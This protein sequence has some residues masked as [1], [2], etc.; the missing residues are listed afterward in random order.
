MILKRGSTVP[1]V[2]THFW[3]RCL[4]TPCFWEL[5]GFTV[6]IWEMFSNLTHQFLGMVHKQPPQF[7][8]CLESFFSVTSAGG[9]GTGERGVPGEVPRHLLLFMKPRQGP[10]SGCSGAEEWKGRG[11]GKH[12][13]SSRGPELPL[14]GLGASS[15]SGN[16]R[17]KAVAGASL[18]TLPAPTLAR[19]S[20]DTQRHRRSP[21]APAHRVGAGAASGAPHPRP[22]RAAAA[23]SPA[24]G[25]AR[26]RLSLRT[27]RS[28]SGARPLP[29]ARSA[30]APPPGGGTRGR[31]GISGRPY[32]TLASPPS[33]AS[34]WL[35][36]SD[37][38]LT[39]YAPQPEVAFCRQ[40]PLVCPTHLLLVNSWWPWRSGVDSHYFPHSSTSPHLPLLYS[41]LVH[42]WLL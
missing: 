41:K 42:S 2:G 24:S 27:D 40:R 34:R 35:G 14:R 15:P 7:E 18:E 26:G 29:F 21:P 36:R 28:R 32:W 38:A 20:L 37:S 10:G 6:S 30:L 16:K 5:G 19:L 13:D 23:Y 12:K 4:N 1:G 17:A 31:A 9:H 11:A 33:S 25:R 22:P 8:P 3:D 39:S